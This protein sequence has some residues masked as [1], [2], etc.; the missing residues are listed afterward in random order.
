[1]YTPRRY[2]MMIKKICAIAMIAGSLI[3]ASNSR[4]AFHFWAIQ[5][6]YSNSSGTLQFIEFYD[7]FG[8]QQFVGLQDVQVT[9]LANT[10]TNTF[11]IPHH[12]P[13][14][15]NPQES[16][17][18]TFLIGTA[19]IQAAGGPTPDF[20]IPNGFLFTA[21]GTIDFFGLNGGPY[22]ALPTD[23]SLSRTWSNGSNALNT[24]KNFAGQTGTVPE[25]T[26][27]A[28]AGSAGACALFLLLRRRSRC[29]P[30]S[31]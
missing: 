7:A 14:D 12:L 28:L 10:L 27:L 19:G 22:T 24:P 31:I 15:A 23:G 3:A 1:M 2:T 21:G 11:T 25:P 30:A 13:T 20:I 5:E 17:Q 6:V 18:K 4:A 26:T 8:S 9:N 29:L 16:F